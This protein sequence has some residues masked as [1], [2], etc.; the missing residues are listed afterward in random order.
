ME[1]QRYELAG[2]VDV[3]DGVDSFSA[4]VGFR[5]PSESTQLIE[6]IIIDSGE[7]VLSDC[8]LSGELE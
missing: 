5:L 4:S 3:P 8:V 2:A 6:L 7:P 1:P